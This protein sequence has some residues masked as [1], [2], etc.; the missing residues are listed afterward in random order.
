M[1]NPAQWPD[2]GLMD[3]DDW[4]FLLRPLFGVLFLAAICIPVRIAMRYF[5]DGKIKRFLSRPL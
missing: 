3:Y 4:A 2:G 1:K 5:P